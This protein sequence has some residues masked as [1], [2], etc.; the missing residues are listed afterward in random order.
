MSQAGGWMVVLPFVSVGTW[1]SRDLLVWVLRGH[2]VASS[3]ATFR[4]LQGNPGPGRDS[5]SP[6]RCKRFHS[7]TCSDLSVLCFPR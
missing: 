2:S 5:F 3:D 6:S 4:V 7:V 1:L